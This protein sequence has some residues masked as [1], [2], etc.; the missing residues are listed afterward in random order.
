MPRLRHELRRLTEL[1]AP[2]VVGQLATMMLTVV[3]TLM[4]GNVGVQTLA[5]AS[6]GHV[7]TYGTMMFAMGLVF[8]IDPLVSQAFGAG[9]ARRQGLALQRG[10]VL[11]LVV[12]LPVAVLWW[13][14]DHAMV[15][16]GQTPE[17]AALARTYVVVQIPSLPVF[18]VFVA[19][20]QYLQARGIVR[21]AMVVAIVANVVNALANWVLIYGEFGL[22]ALGIVGAGLATASTRG[23]LLV[24]LLWLVLR[25][26]MH[27]DGWTGW[28]ADTFRWSGLREVFTHGWPVGLQLSFEVWAF[29]AAT[30]LAG[31]LGEAELAAHTVVLNAASV[32]FMVPMGVSMAAVTRVGNLIGSRRPRAAQRAAWVALAAGAGVMTVSAVLFVTLRDVIPIPYTQDPAV[33]ALAASVFPIAAA[34]QLFDGTQVVGGGVLRGMGRTRP[35]ALFNLVGYYVLALPLAAWLTFGLGWGL[36]GVWWGLATGLA[37]VALMLLAWIHRRGPATVTPVVRPAG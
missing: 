11:G 16:L 15:L 17:L 36:H 21:P 19:L 22:P 1:A 32:S 33:R 7:W 6:L 2:V 5:A 13:T 3:D 31:W 25:E 4:V 20:R 24:A 29:Q 14:T 34:F 10:I 35:V 26:R 23:F 18:M 30:L 9:D 8:G 28:S 12:S 27:R 37:T